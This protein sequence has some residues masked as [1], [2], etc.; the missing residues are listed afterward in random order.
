MHGESRENE[1][2]SRRRP[3]GRLNLR[4]ERN[5]NKDYRGAS[6]EDAV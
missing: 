1:T 6:D 5:M 4:K 2:P 3:L